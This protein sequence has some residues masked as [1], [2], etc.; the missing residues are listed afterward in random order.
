M[1]ASYEFSDD[2]FTSQ[3]PI[4]ERYVAPLAGSPC[5]L[6]EIGTHEGRCTTWLA[7]HVLT[8]PDARLD[9]IDLQ[10]RDSLRRNVESTGRARQV[11]LHEG[12]S[13][14]VLRQLPLRSYDF[15]YV[16]GSHQ[17]VDVLEDAVAAFRLAKLGGV[18]AFDDYLWDAPP[19][20]V[21]GVPKP[22]IDAFL[23]MYAHPTR[24]RPMV[25]VL[26]TGWQVW[27]R[28]LIESPR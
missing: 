21:F 24:Y 10:I 11:S 18:I 26:E 14:H 3:I 5:A 2:W 16:D 13:R 8:H 20:N 12:L 22:A 17:T 23:A 4:F 7:E 15:I 25:Q 28:K 19:W 27:V 9:G 1:D 6:L